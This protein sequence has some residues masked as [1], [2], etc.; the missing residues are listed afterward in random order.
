[1]ST[2]KIDPVKKNDSDF[3]KY[4]NQL[5]KKI[6]NVDS[7]AVFINTIMMK[8]DIISGIFL[9]K[10]L[11]ETIR[12]I[13]ISYY[14]RTISVVDNKYKKIG[15]AIIKFDSSLGNEITEVF[16]EKINGFYGRKCLYTEKMP[17]KIMK[18]RTMWRVE[19]VVQ[20]TE[21]VNNYLA[22]F[23][24]L[25]ITDNNYNLQLITE[26]CASST[27]TDPCKDEAPSR[28]FIEYYSNL[29]D[30]ANKLF[31][32]EKVIGSIMP[33]IIKTFRLDVWRLPSV[34]VIIR[35]LINKTLDHCDIT[36]LKIIVKNIFK[37]IKLVN[38]EFNYN[39]ST[40]IGILS[41]ILTYYKHTDALTNIFTS[42]F[43]QTLIKI[44]KD[45]DNYLSK[46]PIKHQININ[47]KITDLQI[48]NSEPTKLTTDLQI[49][50][51]EPTKLTPDLTKLTG[52]KLGIALLLGELDG[53][54]TVEF[55]Q[56]IVS[57]I[58][59]NRMADDQADCFEKRKTQ[60]YATAN[61]INAGVNSTASSVYNTVTPPA[62]TLYN[63]VNNTLTTTAV[64]IKN[65]V[66]EH[67][68]NFQEVIASLTDATYTI[69]AKQSKYQPDKPESLFEDVIDAI[70]NIN[71][72]IKPTT[73]TLQINDQIP[74]IYTTDT[75]RINSEMPSI[76]TDTL[77]INGEMPSIYTD[78]LR[79]N[80]E[81]PSI[82]TTDTMQINNIMPVIY[83]NKKIFN[84]TVLNIVKL[85][86]TI[87][88]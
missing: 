69:P 36:E 11:N 37:D 87:A 57:L 44:L 80:G 84:K 60:M 26:N 30:K 14:L 83:D 21:N 78:T 10:D 59:N 76:Y 41:T 46:T 49:E 32:D 38:Y 7:L 68:P 74:V 40:I 81:M 34:N 43:E 61:D 19:V 47:K 35:K 56:Y 53:P 70:N 31:L 54:F 66:N 85:N 28:D 45:P 77:R 48:E 39:D 65:N 5:I 1:M 20:F 67:E 15:N 24:I 42:T 25:R 18:N 2:E 17:A 4:N 16:E 52:F 6:T 88:I 12:K 3:L 75:L 23:D 86:K 63:A 27:N 33:R 82:Y 72:K 29:V 73:E 64:G 50:N 79:I 22:L 55:K 13:Y 71:L 51:S 58:N 62:L 8:A 9:P